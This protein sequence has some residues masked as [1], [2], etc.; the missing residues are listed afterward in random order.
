MD[1]EYGKKFHKFIKPNEYGANLTGLERR[2][3]S[4]PGFN[5]TITTCSKKDSFN[6][7]SSLDATKSSMH[8]DSSKKKRLGGSKG[9]TQSLSGIM[10]TSKER[11]KHEQEDDNWD[12][13]NSKNNS[14]FVEREMFLMMQDSRHLHVEEKMA[15][16]NL[17]RWVDIQRKKKSNFLQKTSFIKDF[18]PPLYKFHC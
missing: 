9:I 13:T 4:L 2:N 12:A 5:K 18:S 1:T 10:N 16:K 17:E 7:Q 14:N 8:Q 15:V 3:L 11:K 6:V